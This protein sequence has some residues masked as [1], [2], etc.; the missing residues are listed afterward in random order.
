MKWW[1][2]RT[3]AQTQR[4]DNNCDY[5]VGTTCHAQYFLPMLIGS[6][7]FTQV[8]PGKF[9]MVSINVLIKSSSLTHVLFRAFAFVPLLSNVWRTLIE[10]SSLTQVT[11]RESAMVSFLNS[12]GKSWSHPILSH[13]CRA[14][15]LRWFRSSAMPA[16]YSS[17]CVPLTQVSSRKSAMLP[18]LYSVGLCF[19]QI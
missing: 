16:L 14:E 19:K 15:N 3:V 1:L 7:S 17:M 6:C 2:V 8:P 5:C 12:A 11:L 9:V 13:T 4:G 10:P 18:F